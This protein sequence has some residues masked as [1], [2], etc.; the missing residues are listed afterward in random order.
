MLGDW[1][2][3]GLPTDHPFDGL[4]ERLGWQGK[5]FRSCDDVDPLIFGPGIA[6]DPRRMPLGLALRWPRLAGSGVTCGA[7]RLVLP[8]FRTRRPA[9]RLATVGFRGTASAAMIY[10]RQPIVDHF[11][12]IDARRVLGLMEMRRSAP[13]FFLLASGGSRAPG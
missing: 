5:R 7:F 11:R 2:G 8:V 3:V 4:L 1:S 10:D 9:A 13:Y 12:R 6:L